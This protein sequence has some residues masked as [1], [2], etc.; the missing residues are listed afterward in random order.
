MIVK[1]ISRGYRAPGKTW[2]VILLSLCLCVFMLS[3]CGAGV[4]TKKVDAVTTTST[5]LAAQ[6]SVSFPVPGIPSN[7]NPNT[8][9]GSSLTTR[10]IMSQ[11]WPSAF[12]QNSKYQNVLNA[13]L[14]D[15]AEL[16]STQPETIV[17]R[18]NPKAKWSNGIPISAADF[19]YN[20][21]AQ[22]GNRAH[23]DV[24]GLPYL[25]S[26]NVGYSDI[27]SVVGSNQGK[28]VTVVFKKPFSEWEQL[29]RFLVP[30]KL[31]GEVGW[32]EGFVT[33]SPRVEVSGGPYRFAGYIPGHQLELVRNPLY[34]STPAS[35]PVIRFVVNPNP[36]TYP[37]ELQNGTLGLLQTSF[38][39]VLYSDI[40]S[41]VGVKSYLVPSLVTQELIFNLKNKFLS[42][43]KV[44][45]AILLAI[46]RQKI[47]YDAIG[48][49]VPNAS[50]AGNNIFCP[51]TP[52]YH[53]DGALFDASNPTKAIALLGSDGYHLSAKGV[54]EKQGVPLDLTI[55]VDQS[56]HQLLMVEQ[57]IEREL[58]S[59]GIQVTQ[60]N[61]SAGVLEGSLLPKG[62]Y[63]MAIV[64]QSGSPNAAFG[65]SRYYQSGSP[66][67][68][69]GFKNS[70]ADKLITE[71]R[72]QLDPG[73]SVQIYNQLDALIW[74]ELPSVP[75][76][77]S[78]DIL[79]FQSGYNFIGSSSASSTIFWNANNWK[80]VPPS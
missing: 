80:F 1:I 22:S 12:Y 35:I 6:G 67:N 14:L 33:P 47:A 52:Q 76:Y 75:L 45:Q 21:R 25:A 74:K 66:L 7:F 70:E 69:T 8:P 40:Q 15:G 27:K 44:R 61:V 63:D 78:P 39:G 60:A 38:H 26:S 73:T 19:I 48:A 9:D 20:W 34:W 5:T 37:S 23:L 17:Y 41:V 32:N 59:I 65:G 64:G 68:Y 57:V 53:N 58:Q 54:L 2:A 13:G 71:A 46:D 4:A 24:T 31:G 28:T 29:F 55:A 79:A 49:F 62:R 51:G 30:S 42:D 36:G 50:S 3:A 72:E 10:E 77:S 18:I 11:V 16:I 43:L 56:N